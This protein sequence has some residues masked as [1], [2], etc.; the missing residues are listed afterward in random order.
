MNI[1]KIE[2]SN[3]LCYY[4]ENEIVLGDTTVI[5]GQNNTGKSKLFDAINWGFFGKSYHTET[6][7]WRTTKEWKLNGLDLINKRVLREANKNESITAKVRLH[8]LGDEE[9]RY[10]IDRE[11]STKVTEEGSWKNC[12]EQLYVYETK[13][14]GDTEIHKQIDGEYI[15]NSLVPENL[16]K[17]FLF[18]G[19][20]VS[21]LLKLSDKQAYG[22]AINQMARVDVL[23]EA[24]RVSKIVKD[25]MNR[26][27]QKVK[28]ENEQIRKEVESLGKEISFL[29][30]N[31]EHTKNEKSR[32]NE[33]YQEL[34]QNL[35]EL[36]NELSNS[37]EYKTKLNALSQ[38]EERKKLIRKSYDEHK[39]KASKEISNWLTI[40]SEKLLVNFQRMVNRLREKK[41]V[42]QP[43]QVSYL[44]EMLEK[45]HCLVCDRDLDEDSKSHIESLFRKIQGRKSV[46]NLS[47]LWTLI[48]TDVKSIQRYKEH[49]KNW[50]EV[51]YEKYEELKRM[52]NAIQQAK[53]QLSEVKP[54]SKDPEELKIDFNEKKKTVRRFEEERRDIDLEIRDKDRSLEKWQQELKE[55]STR[56]K[57]LSLSEGH[58]KEVWGADVGERL[59]NS[60]SELKDK[61]K[62]RIAKG[63]QSKANQYFEEMTSEN[64]AAVG[65]LQMDLHS[66]GVHMVDSEENPIENV[67]QA[68]RVSMQLSFIAGLLSEAGDALGTYFP[69]IADAP[70]SS[71]GGDNKVAAVR[72]MANA[73]EQSVII[74][75]DD[76][77]SKDNY[78]IE[79][80][81]MRNYIKINDV[82]K[83]FVLE[84]SEG[85]TDT[86]YTKVLPL[87]E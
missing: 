78:S 6:E 13:L 20:S 55:K 74:L 68:T 64:R 73:F 17:Y 57:D 8:L 44:K 58:E 84:M 10:V 43:V 36:N 38:Q 82:D 29:E 14:T 40:P 63:I 42:P 86:Q 59:Y 62:R 34:S 79:N 9:D 18:Q 51:E 54:A 85:D 33:K 83:A 27:L 48:E 60:T 15:I 52:E 50:I 87:K 76:V 67:N 41:V 7:M 32:L 26:R 65:S 1:V 22:S 45:E 53:T 35:E 28:T 69:F 19:E 61:Y 70:V 5:L 71:L 16:R 47:Q 80:D 46:D 77:V 21:Q 72:S 4:G 37:V 2:L 11:L 24:V 31:I 39:D 75:K 49:I 25:R 3:F 23:D 12:E 30:N 56:R 81:P 66:G